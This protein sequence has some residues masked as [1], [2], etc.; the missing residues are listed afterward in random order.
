MSRTPGD[1]KRGW[2][3]E[4][5]RTRIVLENRDLCHCRSLG[6]RHIHRTHHLAI[7]RE[8]QQCSPG[9]CN[10]WRTQGVGQSASISTRRIIVFQGCKGWGAWM[11]TC[12]LSLQAYLCVCDVPRILSEHMAGHVS[13]Q[14]HPTLSQGSWAELKLSPKGHLLEQGGV[15]GQVLNPPS[16][17]PP[18]GWLL[19]SHPNFQPHP[20]QGA[21]LEN[22]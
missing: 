8:S 18:Q 3:G 16:T 19:L 15:N 11:L 14:P 21:P 4:G 13:E 20:A 17:T 22:P 12:L 5:V 2:D 7:H 1:M 10:G 9:V 6:S